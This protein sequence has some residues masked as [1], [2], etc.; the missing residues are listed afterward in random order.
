MY[1]SMSKF[2]TRTAVIAEEGPCW[3]INFNLTASVKTLPLELYSE[4]LELENQYITFLGT[5]FNLWLYIY[6]DVWGV[7]GTYAECLNLR[8]LL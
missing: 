4:R 5:K 1:L 3:I 8:S 7:V 6:L 2:L